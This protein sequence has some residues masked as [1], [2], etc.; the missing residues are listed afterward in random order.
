MEKPKRLLEEFSPNSYEEWAKEAEV[1]LKGKPL[2]KLKTKTYEGLEIKP[3]YRQEDTQNLEHLKNNM[4]GVFPFV[5]GVNPDGYKKEAWAIEQEINYSMPKDFN[6]ALKHDLGRGQ[7]VAALKFNDSI[8]AQIKNKKAED[9]C[10]STLVFDLEDMKA[11]FDGID[12]AKTPVHLKA[13]DYPM[14]FFSLFNAYLQSKGVKLSDVKGIYKID[15]LGSLARRGKVNMDVKKYYKVMAEVVNYLAKNNSQLRAIE[16]DTTVYANGGANAIQEVAYALATAAEY[17]R[18]A[19][20]EG[21]D[22]NDICSRMAFTAGV[23]QNFFMEIAKLRALRMLWANVAKEFGAEGDA[24]KIYLH[25]RTA[26]INKT[27]NDQ[28]VN[29][30]RVTSESL[31]A[32]VAGVS[33]HT[34][35][36]FDEQFGLPQEFS[37]RISRNTQLFL[38]EECNLRDTIDPA[39]GSW[40]V[41]NLTAAIAEKAWAL[42]QEIETKGGMVKEV[43][44]GN[45][46]SA[47]KAVKAERI[48]NL[49]SRKD[50]LIGIN[51]Y[52]NMSEKE[53]HVDPVNFKAVY[54]ACAPKADNKKAADAIAKV[55][56]KEASQDMIVAL[57][58]AFVEGA[59]IFAA[60]N[61]LCGADC[62]AVTAEKV[63]MTR[64]AEPFELI[65]KRS[66]DYKAKYGFAPKIFLANMGVLKQHKPRADF[67]Q[68]FF[69]TG[70]FEIIYNAGFASNQEAAKAAL[71]SDAQVI[72]IC[73]TDDTYP[74]IVPE[75]AKAIK[76]G[77]PN[78]MIV[79]A[80]YPTEFVDQFKNDG[81]DEFIHVKA[82]IYDIL[83][84]VQTKL[85]IA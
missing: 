28:Y 68:D 37:R 42:F 59:N 79:L 19:G 25:T 24:Q 26:T 53:A 63:D 78:K 16:V 13:G 31:S 3:I 23:G 46:Q 56:A 77:A 33:S 35:A 1:S 14:I 18:G 69:A 82:N 65:R 10:P 17:V 81:V 38:K 47:V 57:T 71:D 22:V 76:A 8:I 64:I 73:S 67:S 60:A 83:T 40:Y 80:G 41:E 32:V 70:G 11:A 75:V 72:V 66:E 44:A 85:G 54:D 20:A 21:A 84:K 30:L 74:E 9:F 45:I 15:P 61:S 7:D 50:V 5:R 27:K 39:G 43:L 55:S 48:K 52:P 36:P 62:A 49:S 34:V 6:T 51:K 12:L 58:N 29:M 2:E 4:P